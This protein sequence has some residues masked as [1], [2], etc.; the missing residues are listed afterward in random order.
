VSDP[1]YEVPS[2]QI[3]G[4]NKTFF[5]LHPYH[6][7]STAVFINGQLKRADFDD[8]WREISSAAGEIALK[9]A[10]RVGEVVQVFYLTLQ[11][12]YTGAGY[13]VEGLVGV[14]EDA[15]EMIAELRDLDP[16]VGILT[17]GTP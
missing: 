15:E 1:L 10:P 3:D 8:G 2:G 16:L 12:I 13:S 4:H 9:E 6:P 7:G 14:L 11:P 5:V 17:E